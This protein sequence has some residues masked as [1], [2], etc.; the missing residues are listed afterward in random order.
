MLPD[1]RNKHAL[2][3]SMSKKMIWEIHFICFNASLY[4]KL[5]RK[6]N[7]KE[8]RKI[9]TRKKDAKNPAEM[10]LFICCFCTQTLY[11]HFPLQPL[12]F[13]QREEISPSY[14]N[15]IHSLIF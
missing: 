5:N 12:I 1:Q 9:I 14:L 13:I 7:V 8:K 6:Y 3:T 15:N 4:Y 10:L 11:I 2:T